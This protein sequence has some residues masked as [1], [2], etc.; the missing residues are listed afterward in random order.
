MSPWFAGLEPAKMFYTFKMIRADDFQQKSFELLFYLLDHSCTD[1]T[2]WKTSV[3]GGCFMDVDETLKCYKSNKRL[4][5]LFTVINE[6][7]P[8]LPWKRLSA[9]VDC[10]RVKLDWLGR[11]FKNII[12]HFNE[13][14]LLF[15]VCRVELD[16]IQIG[17]YPSVLLGNITV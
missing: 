13:N 14:L 17:N 10:M 12:F 9:A 8:Q 5:R 7:G 16:I 1:A 6:N 2:S 11:V 15:R 3:D 4:A